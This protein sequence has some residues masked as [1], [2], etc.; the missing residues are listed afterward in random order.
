[1]DIDIG[2]LLR[3]SVSSYQVR[4]YNIKHSYDVRDNVQIRCYI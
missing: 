2:R 4:V 1:M 3:V